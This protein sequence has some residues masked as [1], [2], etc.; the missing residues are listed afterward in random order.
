MSDTPT[1]LE[2]DC[3]TGV[4]TERPMTADE[5]AAQK[6]QADAFAAQQAA[7][8]EA[9]AAKAAAAASAADKLA[10]L[11]LTPEEIAALKG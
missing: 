11:G 9:D 10:K 2:I 4:Q 3:T 8:A 7:Q 1:V 6:A 5:I